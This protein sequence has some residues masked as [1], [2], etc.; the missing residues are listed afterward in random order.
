MDGRAGSAR[1]APIL[2]PA[3]A[4]GRTAGLAPL[5]GRPTPRALLGR[6]RPNMS[7][8]CCAARRC[9]RCR[10]AKDAATGSGGSARARSFIGGATRAR[11]GLQTRSIVAALRCPLNCKPDHCRSSL[12]RQWACDHHDDPPRARHRQ[13]VSST[14]STRCVGLTGTSCRSGTPSREDLGTHT[15][16]RVWSPYTGL[17]AMVRLLRCS[18]RR[19]A[20]D[21]AGAMR[22]AGAA[23]PG[24]PPGARR[25][26]SRC[27]RD[28]GR[29]EGA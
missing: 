7:A 2:R 3:T 27:H 26:R 1:L 4:V 23:T 10:C 15:Q 19:R 20:G 18:V 12:R 8:S 9:P 16:E 29:G 6:A 5:P 28:R 22:T 13:S 24:F 11:C 21:P 14:S 25:T 17:W